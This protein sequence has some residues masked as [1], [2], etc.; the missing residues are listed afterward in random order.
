MAG[1]VGYFALKPGH[2]IFKLAEPVVVRACSTLLFER[3]DWNLHSQQSART[4]VL[5][6][7]SDLQPLQLCLPVG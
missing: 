3:G 4:D 6:T 7:R 1:Q 5:H 2:L